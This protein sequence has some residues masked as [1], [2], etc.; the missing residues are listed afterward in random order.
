[1]LSVCLF[2]NVSLSTFKPVLDLGWGGR[3][4]G[5]GCGSV[6]AEERLKYIEK[7]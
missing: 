4:G 1:M 7:P 2:E 5:G 6:Y 3:G